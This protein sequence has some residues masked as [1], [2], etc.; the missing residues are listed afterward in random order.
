MLKIMACNHPFRSDCTIVNY[1]YVSVAGRFLVI[2]RSS[3]SI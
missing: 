2:S 1:T 3:I